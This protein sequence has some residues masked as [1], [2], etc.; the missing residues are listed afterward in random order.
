MKTRSNIV[1]NDRPHPCPL[2]RERENCS[3]SHEI[4]C[5]WICRTVVRQEQDVRRLFPLP[6]REGQGEGER[7]H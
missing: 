5:D 7:N 4:S 2:P 6:G 3:P 1:V